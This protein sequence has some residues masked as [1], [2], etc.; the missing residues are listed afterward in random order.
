MNYLFLKWKEKNVQN[1]EYKT[2]TN[3]IIE[4]IMRKSANNGRFLNLF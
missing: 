1:D 2:K 4:L 3:K